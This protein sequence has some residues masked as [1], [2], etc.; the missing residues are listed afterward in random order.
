MTTEKE[1]D[2]IEDAEAG[3][4]LA[5]A[6]QWYAESQKQ[7]LETLPAFMRKVLGR[8]HSYGTICRAVTACALGAARAADHSEHGGITGFQ[9]GC[10]M[11]DFVTEWLSV[12]GPAR[13][14]RYEHMLFPQYEQ[15]F[16]KTVSKDTAEYLKTEARK[17]LAEEQKFLDER[18]R[19]HWEMLAE[20][21]LPWGYKVEKKSETATR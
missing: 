14:L 20:G 17:M 15:D 1:Q 21:K 8:K 5:L 2:A 6:K 4:E 16:D 9:A 12:K 13:M 19:K 11:W 10:I 7:T 18:V 3:D